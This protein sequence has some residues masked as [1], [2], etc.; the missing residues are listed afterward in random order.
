MHLQA[1]I[2]L[3]HGFGCLLW[4]VSLE[5]GWCP[6][7]GQGKGTAGIN[8]AALP[9]SE[10]TLPRPSTHWGSTSHET[11][12]PFLSKSL[13]VGGYSLG[14]H[15]GWPQLRGIPVGFIDW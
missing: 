3:E 11:P 14:K 1:C 10:G 2:G 5:E 9:L 8:G 15:T 12:W 6:F 13:H 7:D 4:R